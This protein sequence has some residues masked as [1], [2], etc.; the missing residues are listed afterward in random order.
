MTHPH[1]DTTLPP[2][3]AEH[4][5]VTSDGRAWR[6]F[7][8]SVWAVR[9]PGGE[10]WAIK[11][12]DAHHTP[13]DEGLALRAWAGHARTASRVVRLLDSAG[14]LDG[15]PEAL[16]LQRLDAD[17]PLQDH[18]DIEAADEEIAS[19]LAVLGEVEAPAGMRHM[20]RQLERTA[21]AIREHWAQAPVLPERAVT[22]ALA[23]LYMLVHDPAVCADRKLCHGDLHYKNVLRDLDD[24]RWVVIDPIPS[25]GL[26]E[27]EV[28][29]SLRNRWEDTLA[30]G[31]PD[32]FLGRRL[33]RV[34]EAAA[35][36]P[37]RARALA[38]AVAV[39]NLLWLLPR[40]PESMFVQPYAVLA[41]WFD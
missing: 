29:A 18:P 4:W 39:D 9:G 24:T 12:M 10:A 27:I 17:R 1:D 14:D 20:T 7:M 15:I 11:I 31:D 30:S 6:G 28:I 25:A 40:E 21:E 2:E 41:T 37:S 13:T 36:D 16:L 5:S 19:A 34:C 32:A 22:A 3:V 38:Q 23:T 26:R 8:S 35:L 33:D